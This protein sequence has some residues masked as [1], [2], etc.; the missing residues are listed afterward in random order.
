MMLQKKEI[1]GRWRLEER[2]E[3]YE[4]VIEPE[5]EICAPEGKFVAM[6][7]DGIGCDP[8]PGH[9][10]GVIILT[11]VDT[12]HMPPHSMLRLNQISTEFMD[13]AV[14]D[15]TAGMLLKQKGVPD[16][17]QGG[18]ITGK[19]A[20]GVTIAS[21]AESFN[22]ILAVGDGAYTVKNSRIEL[23]GFGA[24]DFVGMGAGIAAIDQVDM[25]ID[26]CDIQI[27]GVT[28][29]AV[30]VGGDSHV[31]VKNSTIQ[32][33]SPDSD[34]LGDF[35]WA[36]GFTGTNRVCQ[37]TDNGSVR[38][39]NCHI[40]G[41][42]WGLLSIDGTMK[43]NEMI[44]KDSKLELS[45]PRSHGYG[46]F[47]IGENHV[48][49]D[50]CD[51]RVDGY[52]L[53]LRGMGGLGRAEILNSR[54]SG[55]RYGVLAMG[56]TQSILRIENSKFHTKSSSLVFKGSATEV[57]IQ[58]TE[59][60]AGN[61]VILQ[62]MDNDE[63]G[64]RA[65]DFKIPVG[66]QDSPKAGRILTA[67]G[68]NDMRL[69]LIDCTLEGNFYNSTTNIRA[70]KRS[71]MGGMGKFHDAVLGVMAPPPKP[72]GGE[73]APA[74][75]PTALEGDMDG[76]KNLLMDLHHTTIEGVI[77]SA[78][79]TYREGLTVITEKNRKEMSNV[80][81]TAAP[82]I[83]NGVIVRLDCKSRWTVTGTSYITA[84]E[85]EP[86]AQVCAPNGKTLHITVNGKKATLEKGVY[87]GS[88]V[89]TVE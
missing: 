71:T 69:Y 58:N 60:D 7:V 28:R 36:C 11:P 3:L 55:Q 35:S 33:I 19:E 85:L 12:Y 9:Y 72:E 20:D 56:D 77:S 54:I 59:L 26:H 31:L 44:V 68:D 66:E 43:H 50:G 64:M 5:G 17:I 51:V 48:Q 14:V 23:E 86:G 10:T 22:G 30:H 4:L 82:T 62:L 37:L 24:N 1:K 53:M 29:T 70:C 27:G 79:Q 67:A 75:D 49:F 6:T 88:I 46:A 76:A 87:Q 83:N 16:V 63:G 45:G 8:K 78:A 61:S 25:T 89:L 81:Q 18:E 39:E 65:N 38:Y 2:T 32:N 41:N 57:H 40:K 47:C 74:F 52:P 73:E 15:T 34:W 21:T 84:L 42:G 80:T 13:A